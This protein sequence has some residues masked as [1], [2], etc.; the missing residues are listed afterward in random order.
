MSHRCRYFLGDFLFVRASRDLPA[1]AEVTITYLN[2]LMS[3]RERARA[4]EKRGFACG[5]ELCSG[6]I[7]WRRRQPEK[8]GA[9]AGSHCW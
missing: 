8:V 2:P 4:L 6:E 5:C 3:F 7:E 9:V 1:G